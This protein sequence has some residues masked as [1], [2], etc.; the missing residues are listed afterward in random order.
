[1]VCA[2]DLAEARRLHDALGFPTRFIPGNHDIGE[3]HDLPPSAEQRVSS[4]TRARYLRHFDDDYWLMD[5]PGWRLI[6]LN[7]QLLGSSSLE[8]AG[9]RA[10]HL[11]Q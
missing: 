9:C 6:A 5:A 2:S 10:A 11:R 4:E 3:S 7:T 8:A 1:M